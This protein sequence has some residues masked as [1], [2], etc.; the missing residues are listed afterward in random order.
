MNAHLLTSEDPVLTAQW[1][2]IHL[3][4]TRL[5]P[6]LEP[7]TGVLGQRPRQG[8]VEAETSGFR[9][10]S[11]RVRAELSRGLG[12]RRCSG[13]IRYTPRTYTA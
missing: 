8:L 5:D 1:P 10:E 7:G 6:G 4:C 12:S 2:A 3:H 11:E 13:G 9:G